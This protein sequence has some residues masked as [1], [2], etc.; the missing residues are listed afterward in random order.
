MVGRQAVPAHGHTCWA[1]Q[2]VTVARG[3]PDR[4]ETF[5]GI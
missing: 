1:E 2:P 5:S 4:F 3:V